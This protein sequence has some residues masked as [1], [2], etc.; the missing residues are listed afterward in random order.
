[1]A[2]QMPRSW[3]RSS[4]I[5]IRMWSLLAL[6]NVDSCD[7]CPYR[8]DFSADR[9]V[10]CIFGDR[11]V[12]IVRAMD[13]S[14]IIP[15]HHASCRSNVRVC[16]IRL[17]PRYVEETSFRSLTLLLLA[18]LRRGSSR[19]RVRVSRSSGSCSVACWLA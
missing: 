19:L 13:M 1:M 16:R 7:L 3:G 18:R 4:N 2:K 15:H 17:T 10:R 14:G 11:W 9:L 8:F 6:L 12:E 5:K